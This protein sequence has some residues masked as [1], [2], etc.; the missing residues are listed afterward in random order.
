ME[1]DQENKRIVEIHGIKMEVD[2]RYAKRIDTYRIGDPVKCMIKDYQGYK[3]RPGVIV[4]FCD[5]QKMPA[6]EIIYLEGTD[7]RILTFTEKS[8]IEIAPFNDYEMVFSREDVM[9]K[10]DRQISKCEE[11]VRL[12][13]TKRVAFDKYFGKAFQNELIG[14]NENG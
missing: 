3:A 11:E 1:N 6:V 14:V 5:F 13:K 10:I 9:S 4:G 8:D 7:L 2:M 12:L